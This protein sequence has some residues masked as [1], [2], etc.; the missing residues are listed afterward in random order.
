MSGGNVPWANDFSQRGVKKLA[1]IDLPDADG[2]DVLQQ[3]TRRRLYALLIEL[4]G[5]ATTDE[6]AE[7]L[8]LHPNGVR[9]HLRRM[10]DAGLVTHR[11]SA[12]PRGRPRDEWAVA[13]G[14]LPAGEP[15]RADGAL[16]RW[17]ARAIPAKP[18]RLREVEATG[19]EIGRELAAHSTRPPAQAIGDVLAALG[20]QPEIDLRAEGRF[21]CRLGNCPYRESVRQNQAVV[22]TLH[23]GITRGVLDQLAPAARLTRFIP[24]DPDRA[25]CE[26]EIDR[27]ATGAAG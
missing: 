16:A 27:L 7:R 8:G 11:R 12:V 9:T 17:L 1:G 23:R 6:L 22:C 4:A 19:R 3:P 13:P 24:H 5:A 14:A 25:G 26:V 21:S 18:A 10:R 2:D 15:P 20:F